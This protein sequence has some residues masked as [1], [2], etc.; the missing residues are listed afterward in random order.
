M[1][2]ELDVLLESNPFALPGE[3]SEDGSMST[4]GFGS[5]AMQ[6]VPSNAALVPPHWSRARDKWLREFYQ[7]S[8]PIKIAISTFVNKTVSIPASISA[9]DT[10]IRSHNQQAV[11]ANEAFHQNSGLL[12]G[13]KEEFKKFVLDYLTADNGAFFYVMAPGQANKP[14]VGPASGLL[15]LDSARVQRTGDPEFPAIFQDIDGTRYAIHYTR[16]I[17]MSNLPSSRSELYG[18][19]LCPVSCALDAA[20]ELQDITNYSYEKMSGRVPPRQIL[21]VKKGGTL[22]MLSDAISIFRAKAE[23]DGDR[24]SRTLL[25]APKAGGELDLSRLDLSSLPEGFNRQDVTL[26][27]MAVMAAAFGLDLRDLSISFG[28]A[29]QT[30]ADAEVQARKGRG[31]GVHELLETLTDRINQQFLPE[32]LVVTFDVLDDDQDQQHAA[33]RD[34]RS[35][36][37]ERDLR[38]GVSSIRTER[39]LALQAG[40]ISQDQ[41]D[42][43]ELQDGRTPEGFPVL[44]LF[45]SG[46]SVM[47]RWLGGIIEGDP[48]DVEVEN[49]EVVLEGIRE[50]KVSL[51]QEIENISDGKRLARAKQALAA[52]ET[53]QALYQDASAQ[54]I[55]E[56]ETLGAVD[57]GADAINSSMINEVPDA[58]EVDAV[59]DSTVDQP[60]DGK[61]VDGNPVDA[62]ATSG[63]PSASAGGD[64]NSLK[65]VVVP[66]PDPA[67]RSFI[68][69]ELAQYNED[70]S[71]LVEQ[72]ISG[73]ISQD[74]FERNVTQLVTAILLALF[75]R[76]SR[77]TTSTMNEQDITA[78]NQ[79]IQTN[80]SSLTSFSGSLYGGQEP[81]LQQA[82]SRVG[83]WTNMAVLAYSI[84]QL[85]R[86]DDPKFRWVLGNTIEHCKDCSRLTGQVH[87]AAQW[88]ASGWLPRATHLE[89]A[90]YNCQCYLVG[91]TDPESGNF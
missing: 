58:S 57:D 88:S 24:F 10:T 55:S 85:A 23:S 50:R 51:F 84:G 31:K 43:L 63:K 41:F 49:A 7:R 1:A 74:D 70:Y 72:A 22:Q 67:I 68:E 45:F 62:Q 48:T 11:R 28:V 20:Q 34:T 3:V 64:Q 46:D 30:R 60:V 79:L 16:L 19:G 8:D 15:H 36:A 37:R 35:M 9:R 14:I 86:R 17:A 32:N 53:L 65:E 38:N 80:M 75:L 77:L 47:K 39:E 81:T 52:L 6:W 89:C 91:T 12:R 21:Y 42:E 56:S 13:F 90:G 4:G 2:S 44:F 71:R 26:L 73:Q 40:E 61:P 5:V 54:T 25:L 59:D 87:T 27:D 69:S 66:E 18:V 76:G 83:V 29:G 82:F 33:I 78:L